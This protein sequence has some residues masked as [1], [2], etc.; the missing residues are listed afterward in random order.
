MASKLHSLATVRQCFKPWAITVRPV[1]A[2]HTSPPR[3][4]GS[5]LLN[6]SGLSTSRESQYF[7]KER[8]IPRTEFSPHLELIR[9]SEVA[10]F[11]S[12]NRPSPTKEEPLKERAGN[13]TLGQEMGSSGYNKGL[14]LSERSSYLMGEL[15]MARALLKQLKEDQQRLKDEISGKNVEFFA[16]SFIIIALSFMVV[17]PGGWQEVKHWW[18]GCPEK[19]TQNIDDEPPN[20]HRLDTNLNLQDVKQ[21]DWPLHAIIEGRPKPEVNVTSPSRLSGYFWASA[22]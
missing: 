7:S 19:A 22:E 17:F 10:P 1:R 6:L 8:G 20:A 4:A 12:R 21:K 5:P 9:T 11:T 14:D 15:D 2:F 3:L 18:L 13:P 16:L